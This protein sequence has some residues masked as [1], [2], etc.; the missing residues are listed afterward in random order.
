MTRRM[1]K[2]RVDVG[3]FEVGKV[4]EDLVRRDPAGKISSTWL[5]VIRTARIVGSAAHTSG[6]IVI[7]SICMC[8]FYK[9]LRE[10]NLISITRFRPV[11]AEMLRVLPD[12]LISTF[13]E[14]PKTF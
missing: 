11:C 12:A 3:F 10:R 9:N 8:L 13:Q 14:F 6:L 1:L 2:T 7:G 5:T 4:L